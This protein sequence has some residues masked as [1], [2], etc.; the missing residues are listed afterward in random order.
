MVAIDCVKKGSVE[1]RS[2]EKFNIEKVMGQV[3]SETLVERKR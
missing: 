1:R 2:K 3:R